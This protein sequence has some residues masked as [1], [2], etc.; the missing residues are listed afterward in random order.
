MKWFQFVER[1]D[2]PNLSA[3]NNGIFDWKVNTLLPF[4]P[5]YVF[6]SKCRINCNLY[7]KE[8]TIIEPDGTIWSFDKWLG[9]ISTDDEMQKCFVC[10]FTGSCTS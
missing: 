2:D 9:E 10:C 5:K 3:F 8:P 7:M 4:D 6:L 1:T